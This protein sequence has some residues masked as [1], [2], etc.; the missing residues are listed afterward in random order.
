MSDSPQHG[1]NDHGS[2]ER[3]DMT[4]RS[5]FYFLLILGVATIFSLFLLRG[6]FVLLDR[7]EKASQ[8][9]VSPLVSKVPEDTRHVPRGYPQT[10]FPQPRLETDERNQL[11]G[12]LTE[13][14][15]RLYSYGWID[16]KAGTVH[17]PID[18]AMDLLV[19]RG[20]PVRPQ[21]GSAAN[22]E[23]RMTENASA[24]PAAKRQ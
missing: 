24:N 20:L 14:Q 6:V 2:Y 5:V 4:P 17:I 19:Q 1:N 8:T 13:E 9:P 7:M 22:T 15:D 16:Q 12:V 18:R 10:A 21:N 3:R 11:D 23:N